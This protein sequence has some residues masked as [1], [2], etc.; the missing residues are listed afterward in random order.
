MI[1]DLIGRMMDYSDPVMFNHYAPV[2]FT[3]YELP[4]PSLFRRFCWKVTEGIEAVFDKI[5]P[6]I[7]RWY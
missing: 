7:V 5:I 3:E 6:D 4:K 2:G 1:T